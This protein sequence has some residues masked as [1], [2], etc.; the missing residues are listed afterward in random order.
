FGIRQFVPGTSGWAAG[1][2]RRLQ[3]IRGTP[4]FLALVCYEA[5]FP[6]DIGDAT[7]AE[8]IL[9]ITNDAWFDSSIGPAQH[10]HHAR[11]RSVETGLP[12]L[13]ASNTGTTIVTDPLGRITARL[14]EQQVA[15]VDIVPHHRLDGPTLYTML[16]D[17]PFWVASVL[18]LLLGWFGH[19]RERATRA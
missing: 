17:W 19:R 10:A 12:M 5:V 16:G 3:E 15:A 9:N 2:G 6:N 18:A 13:R 7:R 11:I 4:A 1:D 14:D 8:F